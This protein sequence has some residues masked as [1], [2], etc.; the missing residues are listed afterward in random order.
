MNLEQAVI[1]AILMENN[2][3]ILEKSPSYI[4]EKYE[5]CE[6]LPSPE[7]LLDPANLAK[8]QAWRDRWL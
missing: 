1:F 7:E 2:G 3:G 4:E 6:F 5:G 8:L